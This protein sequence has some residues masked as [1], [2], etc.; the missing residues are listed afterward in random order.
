MTD[1]REFESF[2]RTHQ[3]LVF[4]TAMRLV[5]NQAEAEDVTQDVFLKAYERFAELKH[6]P[7]VRGWLR[8]IALNLS[9][10]YLSR[11]RARWS[12]FSDLF[13]G[14]NGSQKTE[15]DFAAPGDLQ[16]EIA[17]AD[18]RRQVEQALWDLPLAQRV[19]LVLFHMEGL[20]YLEIAAKLKISLARVKT[21]IFRG[22]QSLRKRLTDAPEFA[23]PNRNNLRAQR[24]LRKT[25]RRFS[26]SV[27]ALPAAAYP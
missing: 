10:N 23:I 18:R 9:L 13:G 5:G 21:D 1:E 3:N 19:P 25:S 8:K 12:L 14:N 26:P 22:R 24:V 11:Y 4:T 2:L 16:E 6:S 15:A 7:T 17:K 20:G 27:T